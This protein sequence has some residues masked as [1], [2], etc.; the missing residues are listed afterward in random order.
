MDSEGMAMEN[1]LRYLFP[2]WMWIVPCLA[3]VGLSF[4]AW[5]IEFSY[6]QGGFRS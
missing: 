2:S 1:V 5:M 4:L 3:V 6:G